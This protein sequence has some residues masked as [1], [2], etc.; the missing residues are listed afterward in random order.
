MLSLSAVS[1]STPWFA[2]IAGS[3]VRLTMQWVDW[4]GNPVDPDSETQT[5]TIVNWNTGQTLATISSGSLT[6][7]GA[8]AYYYDYATP[9]VYATDTFY[10]QWYA[11]I[12]T[13]ADLRRFFFSV[14]P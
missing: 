2:V 3:T 6:R 14:T 5:L 11:K 4:D 7:T 12:S 1:A 10:A 8:G 9:T 13:E